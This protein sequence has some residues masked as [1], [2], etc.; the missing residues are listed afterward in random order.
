MKIKRS[1]VVFHNL[2]KLK[3]TCVGENWQ[4]MALLMRNFVIMNNLYT[5][6][7]ALYQ[8]EYHNDE[9]DHRTY[10]VYL[11]V[12]SKVEIGEDV[13]M[14]FI[15]E[16]QLDDAFTFRIADEDTM[17]EEAYFLLDA[18]AEDMDVS[19]QRPFYHVAFD[20]FGETM[21]DV[22]APITKGAANA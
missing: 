22:I 12:C 18:C 3:D 17:I 9:E 7:P 5:N 19:I 1:P 15:E 10:T 6:A 8:V 14:E 21:T 11:P 20:V 4:T 16:L 2:L 13:P